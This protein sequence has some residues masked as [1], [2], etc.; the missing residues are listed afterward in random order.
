MS[1]SLPEDDM[2]FVDDYVRMTDAPSRSAVIHEAIEMLRA[3]RLEEEYA[4]AW[5]EWEG[6][7]DARLW[8]AATADGM[9]DE[10]R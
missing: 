7:E 6:S 3:A 4:E 8:D 2:A 5:E 1:I 9:T 10:A